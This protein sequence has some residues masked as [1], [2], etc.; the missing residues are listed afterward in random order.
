MSKIND[1][2]QEE[3]R[4]LGEEFKSKFSIHYFVP[5]LC[6]VTNKKVPFLGHSHQL[7][8]MNKI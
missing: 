3:L 7:K 6:G 1:V 5:A 4:L 8:E 2:T